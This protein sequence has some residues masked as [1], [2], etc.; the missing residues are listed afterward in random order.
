VTDHAAAQPVARE[1]PRRYV[2]FAQSCSGILVYVPLFGSVKIKSVASHLTEE[3][4][5]VEQCQNK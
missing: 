4:E 3:W 5:K 1:D 2:Y